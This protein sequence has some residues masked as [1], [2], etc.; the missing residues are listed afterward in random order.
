MIRTGRLKKLKKLGLENSSTTGRK[1]TT[2]FEFREATD[3]QRSSVRNL[4]EPPS[5]FAGALIVSG[6]QVH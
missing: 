3:R 5:L 4:S 1:T 6:W 2:Y